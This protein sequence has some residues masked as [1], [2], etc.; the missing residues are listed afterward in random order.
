MK[1]PVCRLLSSGVL[2]GAALLAGV[3]WGEALRAAPGATVVR[4]NIGAP[5]GATVGSDGREDAPGVQYSDYRFDDS[6]AS[7]VDA[8]ET[9]RAFVFVVLNRKIGDSGPRC[10]PDPINDGLARQ[11][12]L[13][14]DDPTAC[15]E[16]AAYDPRYVEWSLDADLNPVA[17]CRLLG[18]DSMRIR[19][20]NLYAPRLPATTAVDF[21]I[22]SFE[23]PAGHGGFELRSNGGGHVSGSATTRAVSF[24]GTSSLYRYSQS[25]KVKPFVV[26]GPVAV[27]LEMSFEKASF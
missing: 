21:L 4:F 15:S 26:G 14:I 10:S 24:Q 22:S 25:T 16:L 9:S 6:V 19:L 12:R 2:A 8:Q 27:K 5:A 7:C 13:T 23:A 17:P 11:V 20:P 18:A 1:G 3:P